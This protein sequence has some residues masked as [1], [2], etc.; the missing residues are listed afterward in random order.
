MEISLA[1]AM[2]ANTK[3]FELTWTIPDLAGVMTS[4]KLVAVIYNPVYLRDV[5]ERL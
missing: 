3:D 5:Y 2:I 4:A 1:P